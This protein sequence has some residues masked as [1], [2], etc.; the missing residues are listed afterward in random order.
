MP[1]ILRIQGEILH[2]PSLARVRLSSTPYLGRPAIV[3]QTYAGEIYHMK[4]GINAWP[5]ANHDYKKVYDA[6]QECQT[7]LSLIPHMEEEPKQPVL[8]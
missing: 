5:K 8:Q 6:M 3:M 2:I 4:Y 7:A 1:Q